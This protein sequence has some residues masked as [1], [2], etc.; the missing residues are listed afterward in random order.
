MTTAIITGIS[1]QDGSYMADLLLA[2]GYRVV[3]TV[4]S[5]DCE[6]ALKKFS[7]LGKVEVVQCNLSDQ[8]QIKNLILNYEP[9]EIYN[10]SAFSSGAGMFDN[11][12]EMADINGLAVSRI[13]EVIREINPGIRFCQASSSEMFGDV[14]EYPQNEETEFKPR[15]PYG[16]A[17]LFA[18]WL[19]NIYRQRYG[20]YCCSA[21]LF[22]HESPRRKLG[23]VTRKITHN[24]AQIKFNL[25]KELSL[26]NL[27]S[28]RDWGYAGDYVRAMWLM[29]Q[30]KQA[31][32]YVIATGETHSVREF[33]ETAFTYV[34]LD[35]TKFVHS[36]T[37]EYR[38]NDDVR[39][40]GDAGK[41]RKILNWK[42][43]VNF[44]EL[45]AMMVE[46]DI[47]LLK[48]SRLK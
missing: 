6:D 26:G 41:A 48:H 47:E 32:D 30:Q 42:P 34:G 5:K 20:L 22:N 4:R 19:I 16:A 31:S 38:K 36:D 12:V 35:Y 14:A 18:H 21:I 33:C 3:G 46:S 17:K 25:V 43:S 1:G 29:L 8:A 7:L 45:V 44:S 40:V 23:F 15:S 13:L 37:L 11:P 39:L 9:D 2:K 28:R 27:D 10:F 24:V